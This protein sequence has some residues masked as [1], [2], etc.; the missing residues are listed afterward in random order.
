MFLTRKPL[1]EMVSLITNELNPPLWEILEWFV[2]CLL[3]ASEASYRLLS[4]VPS[5]GLLVIADRLL[6]HFKVNSARRFLT[7]SIL[8]ISPYQIWMAQDGRVYALMS[9]L[10][11]IGFWFI[12]KRK[13]L[14]AF[15]CCGLLL[16]S[17]SV[18]PFYVITLMLIGFVLHSQDRRNLILTATATGLVYVPWFLASFATK[19]SGE[20]FSGY[21]IPTPTF[22]RLLDQFVQIFLI[23][24]VS[25]QL[26]A[27][28]LTGVTILSFYALLCGSV[29]SF[30]IDLIRK[31]TDLRSL[32]N[33]IAISL[34]LLSGLPILLITFIALIY[35]NGHPIQYRSFS[36]LAIPILLMISTT[37]RPNQ[38]V[39]T[40]FLLFFLAINVSYHTAWSA[41]QKG[42]YLKETIE[43]LSISNHPNTVIF[44]ATATSLLPFKYY[45]ND[46]DHYLLN[47]D[48]PAG[49]LTDP[50]QRAFGLRKIS[51]SQ[52]PS[53]AFWI[54]WADDAHLPPYVVEE[55]K[56]LVGNDSPVA[57]I[58][59]PQAA[60]IYVFYRSK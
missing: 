24:S 19:L 32:N 23:R 2:I 12:I 17:N 8:A 41:Q 7:L 1:F 36:P 10:Y 5:L 55:M 26:L 30:G 9:F 31:K 51:P 3:P 54:V 33:S 57:K 48:L 27:A 13:W 42:G 56:I 46:A 49:F 40:G 34:A 29:L 14:G 52:I 35:G 45:L 22:T 60:V 39:F 50:L 16:Y 53:N 21:N 15:V 43:S 20:Y 11:L 37:F 59:Y 25:N 44:H 6:W 28:Y 18:A 47:A 38:R 4:I 58:V